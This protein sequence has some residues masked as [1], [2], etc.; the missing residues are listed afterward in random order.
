[1]SKERLSTTY[2]VCLPE[3]SDLSDATESPNSAFY[4]PDFEDHSWEMYSARC[5][6]QL[7]AFGSSTQAEIQTHA[8]LGGS[9]KYCERREVEVLQNLRQVKKVMTYIADVDSKTDLSAI[10]PVIELANLSDDQRE[11]EE[12]RQRCNHI[13]MPILQLMPESIVDVSQFESLFAR[14]CS[15]SDEAV[16]LVKGHF[17]GVADDTTLRNMEMLQESKYANTPL[18]LFQNIFR[19]NEPKKSYESLR[20]FMMAFRMM[21]ELI[22]QDKLKIEGIGNDIFDVLTNEGV[23]MS[24]PLVR[25]EIIAKV[26]EDTGECV[27]WENY[28]PELQTEL[29]RGVDIVESESGLKEERS[30]KQMFFSLPSRTLQNGSPVHVDGRDKTDG[31]MN[32][33]VKRKLETSDDHFAIRYVF[34]EKLADITEQIG[35]TFQSMINTFEQKGW[36]VQLN[37]EQD[38]TNTIADEIHLTV[39]GQDVMLPKKVNGH[40]S[41][42]SSHRRVC[43][44]DWVLV[45]PNGDRMQFEL[46]SLDTI[47]E[48]NRN[49]NSSWNDSSYK[50]YQFLEPFKYYREASIYNAVYPPYYMQGLDVTTYR[51]ELLETNRVNALNRPR[52]NKLPRNRQSS[53]LI[54]SR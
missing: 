51:D 40:N 45:K 15:A 16:L 12:M 6:S 23:L 46:Q 48:I 25:R 39:A 5:S 50:I 49:V 17:D 52:N 36:K 22:N 37:V 41:V 33:K 8:V 13:L 26:Y 1:M 43:Q 38:Y 34:D 14:A 54:Y 29:L 3:R 24:E 21:P 42:S 44:I 7:R 27:D 30:W 47:G 32:L 20:K 18:L 19:V 9:K 11:Y 35:T 31:S 2:R 53:G 4:D 10:G 28:D